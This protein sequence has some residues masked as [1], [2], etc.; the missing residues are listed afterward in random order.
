MRFGAFPQSALSASGVDQGTIVRGRIDRHRRQPRAPTLPHRAHRAFQAGSNLAEIFSDRDAPLPIRRQA[1]HSVGQVGFLDAIPA[2]VRLAARLEARR[3]G[4]QSMP[5]APPDPQQDEGELL[6]EIQ[7][8][9][10]LLRTA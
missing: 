2:L 6:P 10:G 7:K 4:Q 3:N 1:I 5:F 9:L 8:T